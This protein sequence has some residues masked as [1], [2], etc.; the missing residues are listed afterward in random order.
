MRSGQAHS[1]SA[2][3]KIRAWNI[4]DHGR[5]VLCIETGRAWESLSEAARKLKCS[6][7][8]IS[9]VCHG[10]RQTFR[11]CRFKFVRPGRKTCR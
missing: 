2:R 6:P 8:Q 3:A 7:T 11:G 10:Q 1:Q 5:P 4:A 9:R